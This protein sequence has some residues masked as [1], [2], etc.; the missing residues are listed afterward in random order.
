MAAD[1]TSKRVGET[2]Q[3]SFRLAVERRFKDRDGNRQ[4]DFIPVV[5][6][7]KT[8]EVAQKYLHKGDKCGVIGEIQTRSYDAQDGSKRYVTEIR[9]DELELLG[10]KQT[11]GKP[12]T[13]PANIREFVETDDDLP[14]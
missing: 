5:Y 1:P 9:G 2:T 3:T 11:E 12:Q 14:F 4:A 8:A 7:G 6:W 13:P 10:G